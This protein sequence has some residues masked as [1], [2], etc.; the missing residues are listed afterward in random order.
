[1]SVL[2]GEYCRIAAWTIAAPGFLKKNAVLVSSRN[3]TEVDDQ[4]EQERGIDFPASS[5]RARH[6]RR[7]TLLS[8]R[9]AIG[10]HAGVAGH[11]H[12]H[13]GGV[14]EAI[15]AKRQ[16]GESVI[17]DMIDEDEPQ[18]Q[19]AVRIHPQ[20]AMISINVNGGH[21][22]RSRQMI[23]HDLNEPHP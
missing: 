21:S 17:G 18:R 20:V 16:P 2:T 4:Q 23:G 3:Q 11:E 13:F 12:K 15:V 22:D 7:P 10:E 14:A 9:P 8:Q 6:R 1:M 19:P 5:Q